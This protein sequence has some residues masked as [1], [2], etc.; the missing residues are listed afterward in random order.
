MTSRALHPSPL[1]EHVV[2]AFEP[3]NTVSGGE[4]NSVLPRDASTLAIGGGTRARNP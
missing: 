4:P 1:D 3:L 2:M